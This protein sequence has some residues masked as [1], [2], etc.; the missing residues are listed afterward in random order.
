MEVNTANDFVF[1]M[2]NNAIN[3]TYTDDTL[4][5]SVHSCNLFTCIPLNR[6]SR[7]SPTL[8]IAVYVESYYFGNGK[9]YF[10]LGLN[11]SHF[12]RTPISLRERILVLHR[13]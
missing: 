3:L 10:D 11:T 5:S 13:Y 8:H 2:K 7:M 12:S 9:N 4:L 1:L 6:V